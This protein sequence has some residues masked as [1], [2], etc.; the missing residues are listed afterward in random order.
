M[1][2]GTGPPNCSN[3]MAGPSSVTFHESALATLCIIYFLYLRETALCYKSTV[4]RIFDFRY[5]LLK[6]GVNLHKIP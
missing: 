3:C 6:L 2:A 5:E 1:R 4:Y